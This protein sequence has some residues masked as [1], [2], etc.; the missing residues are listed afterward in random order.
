MCIITCTKLPATTHGIIARTGWSCPVQANAGEPGMD[1]PR[2]RV[3]R[4]CEHVADGLPRV[5][6]RSPRA[7]RAGCRERAAGELRRKMHSTSSR[8]R[9]RATL[10]VANA[11]QTRAAGTPR[12]SCAGRPRARHAATGAGRAGGAGRRVARRAQGP[13]TPRR[14]AEAGRR[15]RRALAE[16]GERVGAQGPRHGGLAWMGAGRG[17]ADVGPSRGSGRA[18]RRRAMAERRPSH[19]AHAGGDRGRGPGLGH[20]AHDGEEGRGKRGREGGKTRTSSP[21]RSTRRRFCTGVRQEGRAARGER[22][23]DTVRLEEMNRGRFFH[24]F[25][26]GPTRRGGGQ[27]R[28]PAPAGRARRAHAQRQLGR[29]EWA[30]KRPKAGRGK[31]GGCAPGWAAPAERP[32]AR[33]TRAAGP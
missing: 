26:A 33:G 4:C 19:A 6:H 1:Q 10:G 27:N 17:G 25:R 16:P 15:P 11:P 29:A 14:H 20:A 2:A 7:S 12:T 13:G 21:R 24:G 31:G 18:A 28:P 8:G 23:T 32:K 3:S 30:A 22:K 5:L 9:E